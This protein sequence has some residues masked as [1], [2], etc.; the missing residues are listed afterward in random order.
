MLRIFFVFSAGALTFALSSPY[1]GKVGNVFSVIGTILS[2]LI[3]IFI[4]MKFNFLQRYFNRSNKNIVN[5]SSFITLLII[6]YN[7][8]DFV[9]CIYK[10]LFDLLKIN[11]NNILPL[12]IFIILSMSFAI[13]VFSFYALNNILPLIKEF[14]KNMEK[15]EMIFFVVWTFVVSIFIIIFYS[16]TTIFYS[17]HYLKEN[18]SQLAKWDVIYSLDTP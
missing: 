16:K 4:E 3:W 7:K 2:I 1:Y 9:N 10:Q 5:S 6:Y 14:I 15:S 11:F 13:F 17:P 12:T 8:N 18:I